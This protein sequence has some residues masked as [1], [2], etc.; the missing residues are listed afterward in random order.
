MYVEVDTVGYIRQWLR[1]K[2]F[3]FQEDKTDIHELRKSMT[4][5]LNLHSFKTEKKKIP[6]LG[7]LGMGSGQESH[8]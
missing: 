2:T 8:P 6:A 3:F 7:T 5:A 1:K 4:H